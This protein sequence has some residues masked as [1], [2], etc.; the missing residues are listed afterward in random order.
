MDLAYRSL[1]DQA[2]ASFRRAVELDPQFAYAYVRLAWI[3]VYSDLP[4]ARQAM[5]R[6]SELAGSLSLPG[7]LKF[8]IQPWQLISDGRLQEAEQAAHR[9]VVE[10]PLEIGNSVTGPVLRAPIRSKD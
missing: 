7:Q 3:L 8:I 6:A 1:V 5:L 2:V 10:L 4:K 9:A